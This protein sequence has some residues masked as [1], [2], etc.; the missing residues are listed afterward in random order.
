MGKLRNERRKPSATLDDL[1]DSVWNGGVVEHRGEEYKVVVRGGRERAWIV[2]SAQGVRYR[3]N[4][5][6]GKVDLELIL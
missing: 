1:K 6:H 4:V 5:W 2:E 3:A